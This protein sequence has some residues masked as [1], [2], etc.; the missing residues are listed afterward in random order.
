MKVGGSLFLLQNSMDDSPICGNEFPGNFFWEAGART[1]SI[2]L[3]VYI[4]K[5]ISIN[6]WHN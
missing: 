3:R 5:N 6:R 4:E 1:Y 2:L